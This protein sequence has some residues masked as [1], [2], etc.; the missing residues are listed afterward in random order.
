MTTNLFLTHT[1][2]HLLQ[3]IHIASTL[4]SGNQVENI[5]FVI[6]TETRLK[7]VNPLQ[8]ID[9][10]QFEYLKN[11]N[12]KEKYPILKG[13]KCDKFIF[14]QE[15]SLFNCNLVSYYK[16]NFNTV[17]G[18][19]PDGYKPYAVYKKKHETLSML[20]DTFE[21]YKNLIRSNI[22]PTIFQWS[23]HYQYASSNFLDEIYLTNPDKFKHK[24]KK[25]KFDIITIPE[26]N[27]VS[28]NRAGEIFDLKENLFPIDEKSIYYFNQP[29]KEN[30]DKVEMEFL[31]ELI[32][33]YPDKT[34]Y[35]KLHPQTNDQK[36]KKYLSLKRVVMI[37]SKIPAELF[38]LKLRKSI[39]FTGWSTV[40]ITN[41]PSC[42]LY[43]NLPIYKNQGSKAMD[44]SKLTILPHI[45]LVN[46]P[47]EMEFPI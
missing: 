28:L 40:L 15:D 38:I 17:I 44:Q 43:F 42:N 26:F 13:I 25:P 23:K 34:L 24:K 16:K 36:R 7:N 10:I 12:E 9:N 45:T 2:Y 30:L 19:G 20:R 35:I 8:R 41:N 21:A 11:A 5:I 39:L 27:E 3:S 6:Q 1:E 14:F 18:L 29:F 47:S 31:R 22:I 4:Y 33:L 32:E 46:S 37:D